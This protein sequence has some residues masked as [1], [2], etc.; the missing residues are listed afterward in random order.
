MKRILLIVFLALAGFIQLGAKT[1]IIFVDGMSKP[2]EKDFSEA[3]SYLYGKIE[4][5]GF[6]EKIWYLA[7]DNGLDLVKVAS[8]VSESELLRVCA[9]A[10]ATTDS[11]D[12]TLIFLNAHGGGLNQ[13]TTSWLYGRNVSPF[14]VIVSEL[15]TVKNRG[16]GILE[17]DL[18]WRDEAD[19]T[20]FGSRDLNADG[21][22]DDF[23]YITESLRIGA[24]L[25]SD[26][27]LA[28]IFL[29]IPGRK[30]FVCNSCYGPMTDNFFG[31]SAGVY[32]AT[33]KFSEAFGK[34]YISYLAPGFSFR[35]PDAFTPPG[36]FCADMGG[37]GQVTVAD[38]QNYLAW[39]FPAGW[40]ENSATTTA[41]RRP[42]FPCRAVGANSCPE[43]FPTPPLLLMAK[44]TIR[45]VWWQ[46]K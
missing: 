6:A 46:R 2:E 19:T 26:Y 9:E 1:N 10:S 15:D 40:A 45:S 24:D 31:P 33:D 4:A 37:D 21:D 18:V 29:P 16:R 36:I 17:R 41:V 14:P 11:A 7:S 20:K 28:E 13:D 25:L 12:V 35:Q 44:R 32:S 39:T 8:K 34:Y 23:V 43:V 38:L 22:L 3:M 27:R 42:N 5:V 30:V